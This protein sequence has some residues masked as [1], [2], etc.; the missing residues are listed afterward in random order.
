MEEWQHVR[1]ECMLRLTCNLSEVLHKGSID[2]TFKVPGIAAICTGV[3]F[4]EAQNLLQC[5]IPRL[6]FPEQVQEQWDFFGNLNIKETAL[7]SILENKLDFNRKIQNGQ[8]DRVT[9]LEDA[10]FTETTPKSKHTRWRAAA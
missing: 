2:N 6:V 4:G 8:N 3:Q 7:G 10:K 5:Y 9:Y 1:I